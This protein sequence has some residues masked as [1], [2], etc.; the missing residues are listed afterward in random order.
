MSAVAI[1]GMARSS[2]SKRLG[3]T[4]FV[5]VPG[6]NP[7]KFSMN[8]AART[9][10]RESI[11]LLKNDGNLL[12][13]DKSKLKRVAVIGPNASRSLNGNDNGDPTHSV[14]VLEGIEHELGPAVPVD[15]A[16]GG[17]LTYKSGEAPDGRVSF[18]KAVAI[19]RADDLIL[20][21]GGPT[22]SWKERN[23]T[24]R[25]PASR[26]AIAPASSCRKHRTS[27]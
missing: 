11:V 19:A 23:R 9:A 21:V 27:S 13:L 6:I 26:T 5:H 20:Y 16:P 24:M 10:A 2:G 3:S 25:A 18:Q 17:P 15:F 7:A 8:Q 4:P 14:T 22:P 1:I 12:P